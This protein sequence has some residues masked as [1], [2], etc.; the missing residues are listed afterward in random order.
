M[1]KECNIETDINFLRPQMELRSKAKV[2]MKHGFTVITEAYK[3]PLH[4]GL[5]LWNSLPMDPQNEK[6]YDEFKAE[7]TTIVL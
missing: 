5:R 6:D 3:R 4:Q 2:K 1:C 7:I